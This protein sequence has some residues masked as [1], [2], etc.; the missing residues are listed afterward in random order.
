MA[1][2]EKIQQHYDAIADIYDTHYD[3]YRGKCYHT[4]ISRHLMQ[5]LPKSAYLLD[6]GCGTGLFVEKYM[7]EGGSAVGIDLSRRMIERARDRC[8]RSD[9]TIGTGETIPFSDNT[10][11]AVSSLLVFSYLRDP[12][13]MLSEA[14]RVLKP[15]GMIAVCTLGKK[16]VTRGIPALYVLSEK[17]KVRHVVMKDFG[18]RYYDEDEM[19]GFFYD[20]GFSDIH[21]SW[22][23]FAHIDMINPL[24][25]FARRVEPFVERRLP[26]LAY[27]ICVTARKPG[28]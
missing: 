11:D 23:S 3:L 6:I 13:S 2:Q 22:C 8:A 21:T 10:F 19:A 14:H 1:K 5:A 12:A 7:M 24:F 17:M 25:R 15:G 18:E 9:F 28:E 26:Q 27:N 20:A 4:H 16:L